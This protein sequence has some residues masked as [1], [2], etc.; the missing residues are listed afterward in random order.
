MK[1]VTNYTAQKMKFF[2]KDFLQQFFQCSLP[3]AISVANS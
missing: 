3:L 2:I 1:F